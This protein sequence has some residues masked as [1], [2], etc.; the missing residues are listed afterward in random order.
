M[1]GLVYVSS[2]ET[3]FR[4]RPSY[5]T[6]GW[7]RSIHSEGKR[8]AHNRTET[9][10]S[11]VTEAHVSDTTVT[12]SLN[13]FITSIRALA[14]EKD[15]LLPETSDL[16]LEIND[17]A[18]TCNYWFADHAHR[19]IFWLHPVDPTALGLPPAFSNS[20]FRG[21]FYSSP[22][23]NVLKFATRIRPGGELLGPCGDIPRDGVTIC[24][25]S[26]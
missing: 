5:Q 6:K 16:F 26:P 11:V 24:R 2:L 13:D 3:H 8:Y 1:S 20:H 21:S 4:L 14:A 12:E 9:G 23:K 25:H 15:T 7:A 19:T 10:L 22:H 18:N 17:D